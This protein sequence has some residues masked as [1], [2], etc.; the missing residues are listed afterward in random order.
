MRMQGDT[1]GRKAKEWAIHKAAG[2]GSWMHMVGEAI[3]IW[4]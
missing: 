2:N 1:K 4:S 3:C